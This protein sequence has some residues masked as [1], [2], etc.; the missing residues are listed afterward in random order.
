MRELEVKGVVFLEE[1]GGMFGRADLVFRWT[2]RLHFEAFQGR[3][4][5]ALA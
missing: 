4:M 2:K 1:T 3:G 5:K